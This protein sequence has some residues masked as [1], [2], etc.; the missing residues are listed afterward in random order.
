[1]RRGQTIHPGY[2]THF[3]QCC[4]MP[5][6]LTDGLSKD[7]RNCN[8]CRTRTLYSIRMWGVWDNFW[9]ERRRLL[10]QAEIE[11]QRAKGWNL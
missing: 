11:R 8:A 1:M 6:F 7:A 5:I 3:C 2:L 4:G 9:A 10:E